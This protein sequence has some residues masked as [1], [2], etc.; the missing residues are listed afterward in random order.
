MMIKFLM[1]TI[2]MPIFVL[3]DIWL[4]FARLYD[5]AS[6]GYDRHFKGLK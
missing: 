2:L 4:Y 3:I 5:F 6:K 1:I